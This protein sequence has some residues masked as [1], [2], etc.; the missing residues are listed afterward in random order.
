MSLGSLRSL[1]IALGLIGFH[2]AGPE[3]QVQA[4]ARLVIDDV[5]VTETNGG[6]TAATFTLSVVDA[7]PHGAALVSY[8]ISGGTALSAGQCSAPAADFI[9]V[10]GVASL[11]FQATDFSK[12]V[13][14][15]VCGDT[16]DEP[17]QTFFVN[18]TARGDL[19]IQD[20]QGQATI[21]DDDPA[22]TIRISDVTVAEGPAG[23]TTRAAFSVTLAGPTEN[24]P[25]VSFATVSRSASGGSCGGQGV[26]VGADYE[27]SSGSLTFASVSVLPAQSLQQLMILRVC[28]DDVSEGDQQFEV[29]LSNATNATIQDD[30]GLITITDDEP[31]PTLSITPS[32][33]VS[34]PT[35]SVPRAAA[36]FT[37]GLRGPPTEEPVSVQYA[38]AP[39]TAAAGSSCP[40]AVGQRSGDYLSQ[41]GTLTFGKGTTTQPVQVPICADAVTTEVNETFTVTLAKPAHAA[42]AHAVG[43]AT[44]Q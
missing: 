1:P 24:T 13:T 23:T 11:A 33:Q 29:R 9:G 27:T 8:T 30:V 40:A 7:T 16:R 32:V 34:E 43:T 22:P 26:E 10:T 21:L 18:L 36:V 38:T 37:V 41:T 20:P 3:R 19:V 42:I 25:T 14:I 17:D 2:V 5:T 31:L 12:Q 44:I 6:T 28:G 39:G 15:A 35:P 4:Q